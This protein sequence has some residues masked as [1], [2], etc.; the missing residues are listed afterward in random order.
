VSGL[1]IGAHVRILGGD[2]D[3]V[4]GRIRHPPDCFGRFGVVPDEPVFRKRRAAARCLN[5]IWV[6]P[7]GL[8]PTQAGGAGH[9]DG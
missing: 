2:F 7:S 9:D 3:G 8:E 4:E 1:V 6:T 5:P